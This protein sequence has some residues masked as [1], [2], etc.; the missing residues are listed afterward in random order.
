MSAVRD[1]SRDYREARSKFREAAKAAMRN[2]FYRDEDD[3]DLL[4]SPRA[5]MLMGPAIR[6]LASS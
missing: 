3:W 1:F 4:V 5:Q 6:G 2:A